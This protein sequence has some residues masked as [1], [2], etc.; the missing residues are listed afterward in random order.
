M[1]KEFTAQMFTSTR[2]WSLYV[3]LLNTFEVWPEHDFG[4]AA[5][6]PTFTERAAALTALGYEPVPGA[7]WEWCETTDIPDDLSSPVRL[8]ASVRVRSR[9]GVGQ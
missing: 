4:R 1:A 8:I 2:G 9:M 7:E 5:P 6:V 3:V